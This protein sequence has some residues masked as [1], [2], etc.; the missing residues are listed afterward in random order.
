MDSR[1]A[2]EGG[3]YMGFVGA[4]LRGGPVWASPNDRSAF[5]GRSPHEHRISPHD[6]HLPVRLRESPAGRRLF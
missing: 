1:A 4:A 6:K 5:F 3:P 2:A